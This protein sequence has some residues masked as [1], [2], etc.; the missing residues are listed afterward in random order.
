MKDSFCVLEFCTVYSIIWCIFW[1]LDKGSCYWNSLPKWAVV[2]R[3]SVLLFPSSFYCFR[4]PFILL[5]WRDLFC[6]AYGGSKPIRCPDVVSF[7]SSKGFS[8]TAWDWTALNVPIKFALLFRS[9]SSVGYKF[10]NDCRICSMLL[11]LFAWG[12]SP[13]L[14]SIPTKW[15][16]CI[17]EGDTAWSLFELNPCLRVCRLC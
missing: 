4:L 7:C 12:S 1:V 5:R 16:S 8:I 14:E 10:Y 2:L 15:Y 6:Y 11:P 13:R 3:S 9:M 17:E